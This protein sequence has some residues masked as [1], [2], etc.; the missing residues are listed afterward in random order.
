MSNDPE[1]IDLTDDD[2]V[3]PVVPS[4]QGNNRVFSAVGKRTNARVDAED[5]V[6]IC[7]SCA[8]SF[9]VY[10]INFSLP[11]HYCVY[12]GSILV[13]FDKLK[14][15]G[16]SSKTTYQHAS[17]L[18]VPAPYHTEAPASQLG[19]MVS[20]RPRSL[21][22]ELEDPT[23]LFRRSRSPFSRLEHASMEFG[24][25]IGTQIT[26]TYD[27]RLD[28]MNRLSNFVPTYG[29]SRTSRAPKRDRA[30]HRHRRWQIDNRT[31][32]SIFP[33]SIL[34][35]TKKPSG[36]PSSGSAPRAP[37]VPRNS[38][39]RHPKGLSAQ[40]LREL[41][42]YDFSRWDPK[43]VDRRM[44]SPAPATSRKAQSQ[45]TLEQ[46]RQLAFQKM[47]MQRNTKKLERM[48]KK[49]QRKIDEMLTAKPRTTRTEGGHRDTT[50]K[51]TEQE[52]K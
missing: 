34:Q 52:E 6:K 13:K 29:N 33:D 16:L 41:P 8:L 4:T 3:V 31:N 46:K 51:P 42:K 18:K 45:S 15:V 27:V 39:P 50:E 28:G 25:E 14:D 37:T 48:S 12:C 43:E 36:E 40:L 21:F 26:S 7:D 24:H 47:E 20:R 32:R 5:A 17:G 38:P 11:N 9:P 44:L 35:T 22:L 19:I 10:N 30:P 49:T 2:P 23:K 1:I